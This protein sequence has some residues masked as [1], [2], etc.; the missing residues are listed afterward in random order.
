MQ[1]QHVEERHMN[2]HSKH[3]SNPLEIMALEDKL[4][5]TLILWC[6]EKKIDRD[7]LSAHFR[8][9]QISFS[10]VLSACLFSMVKD[11]QAYDFFCRQFYETLIE[12]GNIYERELKSENQDEA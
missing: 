7:M 1:R 3:Q 4:F 2:N 8:E 11:K 9:F 5:E 10:S 12:T 6:K